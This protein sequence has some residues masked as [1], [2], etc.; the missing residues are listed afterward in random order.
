M[1]ELLL[2]E[3]AGKALKD[4]VQKDGNKKLSVKL[5]AAIDPQ[6]AQLPMQLM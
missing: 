3:S 1:V 6:D 4:A 2:S 5:N